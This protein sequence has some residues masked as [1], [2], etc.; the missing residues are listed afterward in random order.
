M[1]ILL[2]YFSGYCDAPSLLGGLAS[3][4]IASV[5]LLV[6][7]CIFISGYHI[8]SLTISPLVGLTLIVIMSG[9]VG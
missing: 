6:T 9:H 5:H 2:S 8:F 7:V 1:E 3:R 4:L